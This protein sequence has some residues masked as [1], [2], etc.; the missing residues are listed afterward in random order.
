MFL[1]L[2]VQTQLQLSLSSIL[3]T[4]MDLPGQ[5]SG[6]FGY[7]SPTTALDDSD[8]LTARNVE[9]GSYLRSHTYPELVI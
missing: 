8:T 3:Q 5:A 6:V 1:A 7:W 9:S 4:I 2:S